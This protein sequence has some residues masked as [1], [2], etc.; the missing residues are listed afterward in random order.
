M[1][2]IQIKSIHPNILSSLNYFDNKIYF[3][4]GLNK[5]LEANQNFYY[6]DLLTL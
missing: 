2:E 3:F 5:N 4:G 1:H 6:L